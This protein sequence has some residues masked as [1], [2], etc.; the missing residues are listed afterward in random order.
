MVRNV[1][2]SRRHYFPF[3]FSCNPIFLCFHSCRNS[4]SASSRLAAVPLEMPGPGRL[5]F[6]SQIS[7][8]RVTRDHDPADRISV[9]NHGVLVGPN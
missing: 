7:A 1:T 2:R 8:V 3:V 6:H 9:F 4:T 5:Q